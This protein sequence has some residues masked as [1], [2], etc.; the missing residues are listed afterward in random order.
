L[1][2]LAN[3]T[4]VTSSRQGRLEYPIFVADVGHD[5]GVDSSAVVS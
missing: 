3:S 4:T 5:L 1:A 2:A